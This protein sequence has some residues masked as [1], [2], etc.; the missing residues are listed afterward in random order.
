MSLY[1]LKS[2]PVYLRDTT[3][4]SPASAFFTSLSLLLSPC[5]YFLKHTKLSNPGA[6]SCS[7]PV[8]GMFLS[9][10]P[11]LA[12]SCLSFQ[13]TASALHPQDNFDILTLR[14]SY[15]RSLYCSTL[16]FSISAFITTVIILKIM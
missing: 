5:S 8:P 12:D 15:F 9:H 3:S 13:F 16:D 11:H 6:S 2:I 7:F 4:S 10:R 14:I 1:C